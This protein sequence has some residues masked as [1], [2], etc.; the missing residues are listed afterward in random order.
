M[1]VV[2]TFRMTGVLIPSLPKRDGNDSHGTTRDRYQ[3]SPGA[4]RRWIECNL[5]NDEDNL[6]AAGRETGS[7]S[8]QL[9]TASA[10]GG[11]L[12]ED[13]KLARFGNAWND[14]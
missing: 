12:C 1:T 8:L 5:T 11:K 4:T 7:I 14:W 9:T 6:A 3:D 2:A 10:G 13:A